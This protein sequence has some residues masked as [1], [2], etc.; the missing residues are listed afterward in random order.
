MSPFSMTFIHQ[1]ARCFL[2][3]TSLVR[4]FVL[5]MLP[6]MKSWLKANAAREVL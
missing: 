5:T 3:K 1:T 4:L 6:K 2:S